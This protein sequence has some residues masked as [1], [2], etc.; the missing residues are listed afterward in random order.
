MVALRLRLVEK[1]GH[2]DD[3]LF[4]RPQF[5]FGVALHFPHHRCQ[6]DFGRQLLAA[7]RAMVERLAHIPL[8]EQGHGIGL[9]GS[10]FDRFPPDDDLAEVE[11]HGAGSDQF[12]LQLAIVCGAPFRSR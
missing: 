5:Q 7:D 9:V 12:A 11:E 2:R 4:D 8:G 6:D 10:G 3:P 1:R